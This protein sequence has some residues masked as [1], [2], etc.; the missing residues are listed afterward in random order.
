VS[1][2]IKQVEKV[3]I[4][5]GGTMKGRARFTAAVLVA[6]ALLAAGCGGS[7]GSGRGDKLTLVAYSTPREAYE[8]L[9]P[10]FQKTEAGKGVSFSQSYGA[11]GDQSRAVRNGLAADVVTFSLEPDMAKLVDAGL[12]A[13]DWNAGPTN[14]MVT[15]SVVVFVVR[16]GNPK[17]IRTWDDLVGPGVE[18]IEPNPFTSGGARWNVMAAYGAQLKAGKTPEQAAAYL[19][20]LFRHVPVQDKSAR[21]ALQTFVGGKGDVMLA[22]ENEAINAQQKEQ[23]VDYVVPDTTILIEN[24]IAV[25]AKS[26]NAAAASAFVDFLRSEPAQR[27]YAQRGYRPVNPAA[28]AGADFPRPSGLFTIR[29]LGGWPEVSTRFFDK[30]DGIVAGIER[31]VGV[32]VGS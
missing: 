13:K 23:P 7:G 3:E 29:D 6:A 19:L 28:A 26:R 17:N 21:E 16:R 32:S 8:Q 18:V 20:E 25:V 11:S 15:R 1:I 4:G 27:I 12:V 22:Y 14:G 10:A 31:E 9:I 5:I 24:P 2:S 30:Q